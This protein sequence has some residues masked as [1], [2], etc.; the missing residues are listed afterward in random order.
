MSSSYHK[1]CCFCKREIFESMEAVGSDLYAHKPAC[2]ERLD[3][4]HEANS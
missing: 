3:F 2:P 1:F 4:E